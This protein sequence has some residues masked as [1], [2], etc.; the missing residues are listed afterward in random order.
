MSQEP[1]E[2]SD[3]AYGQIVLAF[4]RSVHVPISRIEILTPE[5]L[6]LHPVYLTTQSAARPTG[7]ENKTEW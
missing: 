5:G 3:M 4:H 7:P 2:Y 1:G 6:F